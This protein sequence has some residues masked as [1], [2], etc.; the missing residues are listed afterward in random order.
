MKVVILGSG[1][2]FINLIA[3]CLLADECE[4]V[5]VF[6]YDRV[7]YP[8]LDR[9]ILDKFNPSKEYT[10]INSHKLYE[11]KARS[12]NSADFKKEILKLNA[13]LII[14][15]SWG[16][17]IKK[18]II[19]LP[20]IATVNTHPSLLPKYRGP[21]PYMQAIKNL[22]TT[23]G[24][25]FHLMNDKFDEGPILMQRT[26]LIEKTDTGKELR[27]KI[28][29]E[30]R[31]GIVKLIEKFNTEIIIP[32][33]QNEKEATYFN[34]I[35]DKDAML[36]FEN[37]TSKELSAHIRGFYPWTHCY[38]QHNNHFF[39]PNP[40]KLEIITPTEK[41]NALAGEIV[42]KSARRSEITVMCKD[43]KLLKM[44]GVKIYGILKPLTK[45]Y[46]KIMRIGGFKD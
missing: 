8:S 38:Y 21:N 32:K 39:I 31:K 26:V 45:L 5:G 12:A 46:I 29:L 35:E 17:R 43:N 11:I 44:Q 24:V 18:S 36:D 42:S 22:E 7:R 13:D 34:N 14:V 37:E 19:D 3:G 30:V 4:I 15:G 1:N 9:F 16:E 40:Y 25:T 10:Y 28:G 2:L 33:I 41:I 6:R 20:K 27:E 23:S